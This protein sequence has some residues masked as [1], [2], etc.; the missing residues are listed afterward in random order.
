MD[1]NLQDKALIAILRT[2]RYRFFL[3]H[4]YNKDPNPTRTRIPFFFRLCI[5]EH[6]V[7]MFAWSSSRI[8]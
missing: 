4:Q 1:D 8:C 6:W 3:I 5:A 7:Y 2:I